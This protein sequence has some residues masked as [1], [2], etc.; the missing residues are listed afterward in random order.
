MPK[1]RRKQQTTPELKTL[2]EQ[3]QAA[4]APPSPCQPFLLPHRPQ[5][6]RPG[7]C[8]AEGQRLGVE[9]SLN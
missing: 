5:L 6:P 4:T 1:R 3:S 8:L 2:C 9:T 7:R